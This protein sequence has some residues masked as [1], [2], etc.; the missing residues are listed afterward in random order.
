MAGTAFTP[1]IRK[2]RK[3]VGFG[4]NWIE[5]AAH[6]GSPSVRLNI[7]D[8]KNTKPDG[9]RAAE[10]FAQIASYGASQSVVVHLENDN[11]VSEDPFFIAGLI[12]RVNNP[13]LRALPDF[14]NSL[15][16]LPA[17]QAYQGLDRMFARAYA[18]SHV[19]EIAKTDANTEV[20][21]DLAR[22]F[23]LAKTHNYQGNFSME[24]DSPGD[25]YAGTAH[26]VAATIQNLS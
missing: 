6:L 10:G 24:W 2:R 1:A 26:L 22:A 13:W 3:A 12:D 9:A 16:A 23:A 17:D 11:P 21:V 15:A 8:E 5:V 18:I 25:P 7:A 19:K 14:G 20:H 4:I